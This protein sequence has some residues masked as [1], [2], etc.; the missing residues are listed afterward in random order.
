[1]RR[2]EDQVEERLFEQFKEML[3]QKFYGK[4]LGEF[5]EEDRTEL[6]KEML[7]IFMREVPPIIPEV[8]VDRTS[9]A[10]GVIIEMGAKTNEE[11]AFLP[12][13]DT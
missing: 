1:M 12:K 9:I 3:S 13:V 4:R 6:K 2:T 11:P 10:P 8:V 7:A 5:T